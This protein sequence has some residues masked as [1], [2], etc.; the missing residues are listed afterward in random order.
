MCSLPVIQTRLRSSVNAARCADPAGTPWPPPPI[1]SRPAPPGRLRP[2]VSFR[3]T[4]HWRQRPGS[5]EDGA[6][7]ATNHVASTR[8]SR[9]ETANDA[10]DGAPTSTETGA[11]PTVP[12]GPP[13]SDTR[14]AS[15][16]DVGS[17]SVHRPLPIPDLDSDS[18]DVGV[19]IG[20]HKITAE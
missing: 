4:G 18:D 15:A 2:A 8:A 1:R 3:N 14:T 5:D 9:K 11:P 6:M 19:G 13:R 10:R 7:R 12:V 16:G 17:M 20:E